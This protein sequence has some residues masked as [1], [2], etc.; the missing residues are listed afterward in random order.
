LKIFIK[1]RDAS[2]TEAIR[3]LTTTL[4]LGADMTAL[5]RDADL[6]VLDSWA[7]VEMMHSPWSYIILTGLEPPFVSSGNRMPQRTE[8]VPIHHFVAAF[9]RRCAIVQAAVDHEPRPPYRKI[10]GS[11]LLIVDDHRVHAMSAIQQLGE[12]H[13]LTVVS[14]FRQALAELAARRAETQFEAV[15]TD[16]LLPAS[17]HN[18]GPAACVAFTG[19]LMP[20][21]PYVAMQAIQSGV[22]KVAVV[23]DASHHDH[24]M[25]AAL[26]PL[27]DKNWIIDGGLMKFWVGRNDQEDKDWAGALK[28]LDASN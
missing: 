14:T 15:L 7:D 19:R 1:T 23:T 25:V 21:G 26:D 17:G 10:D 18:L 27:L 9:A 8:F 5:H 11:D 3:Q 4:P 2:V 28:A 22:K 20:L 16:F 24:P 13:Q 12:T 6:L